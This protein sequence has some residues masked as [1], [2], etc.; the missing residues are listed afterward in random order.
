MASFVDM[1]EGSKDKD[2]L[3]NSC[4]QSELVRLAQLAPCIHCSGSWFSN[5]GWNTLE[6]TVL[7]SV[8][9]R[10]CSLQPR[11]LP[12]QRKPAGSTLR[13]TGFLVG[14]TLDLSLVQADREL[15]GG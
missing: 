8:A 10:V 11:A 6:S 13:S 14:K 15:R 5:Q 7:C 2:L 1:A 12:K 4:L 9:D 3:G